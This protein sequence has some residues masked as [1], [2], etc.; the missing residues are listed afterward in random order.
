M[1]EKIVFGQYVNS[2]SWIHRLDP[3]TK[4][5][6]LFLM[7]VGIFFINNIY[8]LLIFLGFNFVVVLSSKISLMKFLKSFKMIAMLFHL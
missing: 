7:M 3:R 5:I 6:T 1:N 8:G 2:D 4:I